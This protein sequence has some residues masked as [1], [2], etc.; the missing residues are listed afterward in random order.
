MTINPF[1]RFVIIGKLNREFVLPLSGKP[2][3][4]K[5]GGNL[6]YAAGGLGVWGNRAGL[7]AKVGEEY[8]REWID[9]IREIGFDVR[10][11]NILEGNMDLRFFCAFQDGE[12]PQFDMPASHFARVNIQLPRQLL[13]YTPQTSQ[14]D[15]RTV[16]SL[17]TIRPSDLPHDYFDATAVHL[18]P[19]DFLT[20]TLIPSALRQGNAST[21]T[22]DAADTYM[23]PTF[24]DD[25]PSIVKDITAFITSERK[26]R[27]LF[28]G[29][30]ADLWEM[31]AALAD[32]GCEFVVIKRRAKGQYLYDRAGQKRWSIPAYETRIANP[33]GAGDAFCGGFLSGYRLNYDPVE[34]ALHGNIAAS[35][36]IEGNGPFYGM[37]SMPGLP[38]AR[39][40]LLREKVIQV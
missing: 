18:C 31:A 21:I 23:N 35:L 40:N 14:Q 37:D 7:V 15:S 27:A 5:P 28:K 6:L 1:L 38:Q 39:M 13:G 34:A 11:I 33:L 22:I 25:L 29:R 3:I 24:W 10:G 8:S 20:H 30:S 12:N 2:V 19:V 32:Y 4:D 16:P 26:I 9:R 17:T 36:S